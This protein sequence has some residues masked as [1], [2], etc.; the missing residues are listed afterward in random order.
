M[1]EKVYENAC[2]VDLF[3]V[4]VRYVVVSNMHRSAASMRILSVYGRGPL[5]VENVIFF[6]IFN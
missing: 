3:Y 5:G 4:F 1:T 6:E 2:L